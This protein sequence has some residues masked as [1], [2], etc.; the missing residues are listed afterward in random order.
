MSGAVDFVA[1]FGDFLEEIGSGILGEPTTQQKKELAA[2]TAAAEA[3]QKRIAD[4][5]ESQRKK[6]IGRISNRSGTLLTGGAG[7]GDAPGTTVLGG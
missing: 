1:D 5:A 2:Q 4:L 7:L 3:E 6:R